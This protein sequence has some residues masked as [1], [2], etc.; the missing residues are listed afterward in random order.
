VWTPRDWGDV[1]EISDDGLAGADGVIEFALA[2]G[3]ADRITAYAKSGKPVVIGTTGWQDIAEEA[4]M[5]CE[6]RGRFHSLG[7]QL[8]SRRPS[9]FPSDGRRRKI[10][11]SDRRIRRGFSGVPSQ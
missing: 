11:K 7:Q 4:K 2:D 10:G 5:I 6:K 1:R 3:I 8:L 9:L